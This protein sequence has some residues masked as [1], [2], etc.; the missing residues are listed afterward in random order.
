MSPLQYRLGIPEGK[1]NVD[2][3]IFL[4]AQHANHLLLQSTYY[5]KTAQ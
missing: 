4:V 2:F 1:K 5:T 3:S